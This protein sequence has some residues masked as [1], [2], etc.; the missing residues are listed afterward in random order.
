MD[1]SIY[2][3]KLLFYK[4][5]HGLVAIDLPPYVE[6]PALN[7]PEELTAFGLSTDTHMS[8]LLQLYKYSSGFFLT[9]D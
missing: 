2:T 6:H 8:R 4:I 3:G 5:I 7:F 9:Q 1:T